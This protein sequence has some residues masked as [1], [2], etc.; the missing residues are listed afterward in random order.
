ML[1]ALERLDLLRVRGSVDPVFDHRPETVLRGD[2]DALYVVEVLGTEQKLGGDARYLGIGSHMVAAK[3]IA[4]AQRV[5][6]DALARGVEGRVVPAEGL[7]V[8]AR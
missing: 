2:P 5:G 4:R 3:R 8:C 1:D 7:R 6:G